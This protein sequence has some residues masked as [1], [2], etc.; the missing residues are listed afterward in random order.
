[1]RMHT[2]S[3]KGMNTIK[4]SLAEAVE[5]RIFR[6][7]HVKE[8]L[9]R[10]NGTTDMEA[11]RDCDIV[12]EAIFED[13]KVKQDL[14]QKLDGIC[15]D[16]TVL[17]SNTSSFSISDLGSAVNRKDKFVGLHF[18]YHPAKNRLVEVIPGKDTPSDIT[19]YMMSASKI[20]GK[21]A[22]LVKDAP[23]FAVNRFL[24]KR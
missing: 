6:E 5:R 3:I 17:A 21:T 2:R 1:M 19:E 8:I 13:K 15:D 14:F 4:D 20:M 22:I 12:I 11:V 16:K 18:F 7:P 23:G 24:A 10:I 9:G